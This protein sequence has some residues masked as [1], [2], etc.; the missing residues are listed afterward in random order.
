LKE[1]CVAGGLAHS[2]VQFILKL[3]PSRLIVR[4]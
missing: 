2:Q 3:V 4:N 1:I